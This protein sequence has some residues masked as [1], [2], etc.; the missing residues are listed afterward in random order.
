MHRIRGAL[1][2]EKLT[3]SIN[4]LI[5][6]HEI[7]RTT[8]ATIASEPAQIVHPAAPVPVPLIDLAQTPD[9]E[10]QAKLLFGQVVRQPLDLAKL[11]LL[12]FQ[13]ARIGA[14]EHWLLRVCH[15]I[16]ADA[17]S[18]DVF[19]KELGLVYD[20][21]LH[22]QEIPL[23]ESEP[24]QYADYAAWQR[25]DLR[26]GRQAY[27]EAIDWW[28]QQ[29]SRHPRP[30]ELPFRR[31]RPL[32]NADVNE[33]TVC[34]DLDPRLVARLH[35]LARAEGA[36][37]FMIHLAAFAALVAHDTQPDVVL[38]A[39]MT[40]RNRQDV[41]KMFGCFAN[42]ATLRLTCDLTSTFRHWLSV[43]RNRVA[44]TQA[45][46]DI[47]YEQLKEELRKHGQTTP[48]IRATL[49]VQDRAGMRLGDAELTWLDSLRE[50]MSWGFVLSFQNQGNDSWCRLLFDARIYE[51]PAVRAWMARLLDFLAAIAK[52]PDRKLTDLMRA[53]DQWAA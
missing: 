45:H 26:P 14:D 23:P 29:L 11:P 8:F 33:G 24:L 50:S 7:L 37:S 19:F 31:R 10:Q 22:G 16:I 5:R 25:L 34:W 9:A 39:Y 12:R 36:T 48:E 51:P 47:P 18:W 52:D 38:G 2:V 21:L 20:A 43:V 17:W 28:R 44:E 13:L 41:Q 35:G 49:S 53:R 3:A 42:L 27:R 1:D 32:A 4:Y 15:H 6:R 40:N 30:L 46:S